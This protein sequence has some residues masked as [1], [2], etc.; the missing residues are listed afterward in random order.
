MDEN[1]R[2]T[3][4]LLV[5][6]LHPDQQTDPQLKN[7]AEAQLRKLNR[8][9]AVLADPQKRAH[10]DAMLRGA[11]ERPAMAVNDEAGATLKRWLRRIA[12][13]GAGTTVRGGV[14]WTTGS[15]M[16]D[17]QDGPTGILRPA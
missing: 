16:R 7:I 3:Y 13:L 4:R 2:E 17:A 11:N 15:A 14:V 6:L 5:R 12:F 8:I 10:Y 1:V 9:Y